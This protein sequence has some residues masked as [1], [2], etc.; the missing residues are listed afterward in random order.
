MG[1][2]REKN[3]VKQ[4]EDATTRGAERQLLEADGRTLKIEEQFQEVF[5]NVRTAPHSG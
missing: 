5:G 1:E 3:S 2:D 4:A